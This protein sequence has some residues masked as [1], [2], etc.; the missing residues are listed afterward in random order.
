[1]VGEP[2]R[3]QK[4]EINIYIKELLKYVFLKVDITT[5]NNN[6]PTKNEQ[7][8]IFSN[9]CKESENMFNTTFNKTF[10]IMQ[11]KTP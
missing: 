8:D 6:K 11:I 9:D 5:G 3:I 2:W 10:L 1:M 7:I 4:C